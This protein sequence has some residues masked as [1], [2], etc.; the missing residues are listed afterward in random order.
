MP[1]IVVQRAI[2]VVSALAVTLLLLQRLRRRIGDYSIATGSCS[3]MRVLQLPTDFQFCCAHAPFTNETASAR[4]RQCRQYLLRGN[5]RHEVATALWMTYRLWVDDMA[6]SSHCERR[7]A[8]MG[9]ADNFHL[10]ALG[11]ALG[12]PN[13]PSLPIKEGGSEVADAIACLTTA[14]LL[15][16]AR[17]SSSSLEASLLA[18]LES[19]RGAFEARIALHRAAARGDLDQLTPLLD[20]RALEGVSIN[21]QLPATWPPTGETALHAAA[22][23]GRLAAITLL[24]ERDACVDAR[25]AEGW[26]PLHSAAVG[27]RSADTLA[28][29]LSRRADIHATTADSG[30]SALHLAAFNGRLGAC[31]LLVARGAHIHARSREGETPCEQARYRS[32]SCSCGVQVETARLF[33]AVTGFLERMDKLDVAER[34][35]AAR[36]VWHH[37]VS[38]AL[39]Q[40]SEQSDAAV[41]LEQLLECHRSD[42]DAADHDGSTALHAAAHA[43]HVHAAVR[44][45][46]A[47]AAVHTHTRLGDTPLH[48]AAREGH[49]AVVQRLVAY[50]ADLRACGR[51]DL[52]PVET[53]RRQQTPDADA[54][55]EWLARHRSMT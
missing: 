12:L 3:T 39:Q 18:W 16:A 8:P 44:L 35:D 5:S 24:L 45:L 43:G 51:A 21:E 26:Q 9:T 40:A 25:S 41:E 55:A 19:A 36:R 17:T 27:E 50:G 11:R 15:D 53:A 23:E 31:K 14:G 30:L 22:R 52:T 10:F 6:L 49:L 29:L 28:L 2:G 34:A 4:A 54:V 20:A 38:A 32:L 48:V 13:P 37:A 7:V 42:V 1:A 46:D 33:G 47:G